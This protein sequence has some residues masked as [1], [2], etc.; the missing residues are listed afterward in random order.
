MTLNWSSPSKKKRKKQLR[1]QI[2]QKFHLL[3]S[4]KL[5]KGSPSC[6]TLLLISHKTRTSVL[7]SPAQCYLCSKKTGMAK[8]MAIMMVCM[9]LSFTYLIFK[10]KFLQCS[11]K[12]LYKATRLDGAGRT[13]GRNSKSR[14]PSHDD[15]FRYS[16]NVP[17]K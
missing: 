12:N 1:S 7:T 16:P 10:T 14:A 17:I 3:S 4:K 5:V 15:G 8:K 11:R 6:Q 13:G 2:W 9:Q